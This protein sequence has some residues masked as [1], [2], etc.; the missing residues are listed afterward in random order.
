MQYIYVCMYV[1]VYGRRT[2]R[3]RRNVNIDVIT[4]QL[5]EIHL[6]D[7]SVKIYYASFVYASVAMRV[8]EL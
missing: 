5:R 8:S 4:L 6:P 7:T 2:C 1:C 3:I